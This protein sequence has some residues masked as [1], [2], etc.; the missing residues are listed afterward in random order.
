MRYPVLSDDSARELAVDFLDRENPRA[1]E[2]RAS[3]EGTGDLVDLAPID[4]VVPE[5]KELLRQYV[6]EGL[7]HDQIEGL[8]CGPLHAA[9]EEC[10]LPR[11]AMVDPGFWR[12]LGC[13][14]FWWLVEWRQSRTFETRDLGR[15]YRY[16]DGEKPRISVLRRMHYRARVCVRDGDYH[17]AHA[18]HQATDFWQSHV[19]GVNTG[20]SP[21]VVRALAE[22]YS[23]SR[24]SRDPLREVAKLITR[25]NSNVVHVDYTPEE[26]ADFA[27]FYWTHD[28]VAGE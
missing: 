12:Y 19:Y 16:L 23:T 10:T 28:S 1:A 2:D 15:Y 13:A 4:E 7:D 11:E 14:K 24:L 8:L 5:M 9:L 26:A 18:A 17:L 20:Y 3:S 22:L 6:Q 21:E 27:E 25:T